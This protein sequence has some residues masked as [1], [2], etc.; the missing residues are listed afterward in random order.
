MH[1]TNH[2]I[3]LQQIL[4]I[5]MLEKNIIQQIINQKA[6]QILIYIFSLAAFFFR[7]LNFQSSYD[8]FGV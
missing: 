6:T 8:L 4:N 5:R 7:I 1:I 3:K 2:G